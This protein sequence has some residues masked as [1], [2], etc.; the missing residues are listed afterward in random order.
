MLGFLLNLM[1]CFRVKG[2]FDALDRQ[3]VSYININNY[4]Q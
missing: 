1:S 2:C 4:D 3:Y